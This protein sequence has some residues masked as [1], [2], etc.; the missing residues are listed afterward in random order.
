ML[1]SLTS[2]DGF[3]AAFT[4]MHFLRYILSIPSSLYPRVE[5]HNVKCSFAELGRVENYVVMVKV[6]TEGN[7]ELFTDGEE[8]VYG[9]GDIVVFENKALLDGWR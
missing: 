6:E 5:R 4:V 1:P 2:C 7:V 8:V 9:P 3:R